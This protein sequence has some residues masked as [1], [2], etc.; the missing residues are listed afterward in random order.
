[1]KKLGYEVN[2]GL[3]GENKDEPKPTKIM[4]DTYNNISIK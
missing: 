3:D 1:M 2:D 4:D